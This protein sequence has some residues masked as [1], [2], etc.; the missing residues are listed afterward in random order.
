VEQRLHAWGVTTDRYELPVG[1]FEVLAV[2]RGAEGIGLK[3]R[4]QIDIR[5][6]E[7]RVTRTA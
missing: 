2:V 4:W 1:L 6:A 7:P 5:D 3:S